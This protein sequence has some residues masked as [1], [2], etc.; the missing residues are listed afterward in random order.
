MSNFKY[1]LAPGTLVVAEH[2]ALKIVTPRIEIRIGDCARGVVAALQTIQETAATEASLIKTVVEQV[3]EN[4]LPG[5][6]LAISELEEEL[7]LYR[8]TEADGTPLG[9]LVPISK[10]FRFQDRTF[11]PNHTFVLSRFTFAH[12]GSDGWTLESP[13]CHCRVVFADWRGPALLQRIAKPFRLA[14]LRFP[15]ISDEAAESAAALLLNAGM[16]E[17]DPEYLRVWEFH[18]LLFHSRSRLGRHDNDYGR[19]FRFPELRGNAVK[20]A[21]SREHIALPKPDIADLTIRDIPFTKAIENRRS[22]RFHGEHPLTLREL[23]EFLFRTAR[24]RETVPAKEGELTRRPY[25]GAGAAYELEIYPVIDKCQDVPAGI[26]HYCP[27]SHRLEHLLVD[28]E[29]LARLLQSAG[30]ILNADRP[31]ILL[32]VTAR[33]PRLMWRYASIGYSLI[34]KNV[35]GLF[36]TM[37]LVAS[38][39]GIAACALGGGD[40]DLFAD[41][42]GLEYLEESSVGEFAIGRPRNTRPDSRQ[43]LQ[44]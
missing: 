40:S 19:I 39:M 43:G 36:Q 44:P 38:A 41:A 16:L 22:N 37:Y 12:A 32:V 28:R 2:G 17:G 25:P 31:Q 13:L 20:P 6:Y 7:L 30:R 24:I 8:T 10:R 1:K 42:T 29:S 21:M 33:F 26:Y 35:G 27:S 14:D 11:D 4:A 3:G 23:G 15:P 34:L 9:S 5:L 18:D